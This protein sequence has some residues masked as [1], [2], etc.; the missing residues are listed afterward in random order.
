MPIYFDRSG[1]KRKPEAEFQSAVIKFLSI[2]YGKDFWYINHLGGVGQRSGIPDLLCCIRGR[3][4]ALE[5]KSPKG[6]GRLGPK[7][8]VEMEAIQRAGGGAYVISN[9]EE[10]EAALKEWGG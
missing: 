1:R 2:R 3:F 10:L 5:I 7:Q 9:F 6:A 4:L 8:K